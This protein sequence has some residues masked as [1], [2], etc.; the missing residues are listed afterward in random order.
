MGKNLVVCADGT[1]KGPGN[2]LSGR[3][4]GRPPSNVYKLFTLLAGI[5]TTDSLRLRDEQE[6]F[7]AAA[8]DAPV[9]L[10]KYIHGVGDSDNYLV[11]ILGGI[12]G[13]GVVIRI[14]RAYTFI[15]RHYEPGDRI[16]LAGFSRGAYTARA[17]GGLIAARGLLDAR[18]LDLADKERAYRL[19][20]AV[21]FDHRK[22]Q[23]HEDGSVL[24][25][26]EDLVMDLPAWLTLP[27]TPHLIP[28]VGIKAIGVWETVGS[29]GI[30]EYDAQG[31]RIE[32]LRFCNADL[33]AQVEYGFHAIAVDEE[34]ADFTPTFWNARQDVDQVLFPGAHADV[35]GG[36]PDQESG[37]AN[38]ALNWMM[39]RL[40]TAGLRFAAP[41]PLATTGGPAHRP[42]RRFPYSMLPHETRKLSGGYGLHRSV[43]ERWENG[44]VAPDPAADPQ[45]YRPANLTA[46]VEDG[47]VRPG[48]RVVA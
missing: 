4:A 44:L 25:K 32:A 13:S 16:Y 30:P 39:E 8:D 2:E 35:G 5:D 17:L 15:S 33:S 26:L 38:G 45:P 34:R 37:L 42:W 11:R 14:V 23:M 43:L 28:N 40:H 7:A 9:Q 3:R 47:Q 41:P 27:P 48:V 22:S 20:A 36:Y 18:Q 21:W 6:R 31:E 12:L 29:L 46:Y 10:A 24:G 1:W 19:G